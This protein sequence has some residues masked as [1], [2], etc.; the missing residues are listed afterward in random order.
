MPQSQNDGH[1]EVYW[2]RSP[3]QQGQKALAP[4]L[5]SLEGKTVA[6]LWDYAFSGDQVFR[7][8][9][10]QMKARFPGVRFINWQEF[11]NTH[12]SEE[13]EVLAALPRRLKEFGA[14]AVISCMAC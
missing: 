7:I 14:D 3:K 5:P 9:E 8:L 11:G 13:R 4:R 12:G 1:Y 2:P 6:Q 10:E